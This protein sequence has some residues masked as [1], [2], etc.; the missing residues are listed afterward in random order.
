MNEHDMNVNFFE[1][2]SNMA[3]MKVKVNAVW[4]GGVKGNGTLK[5]DHD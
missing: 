4:D 5:T 1:G 3:D 2:V